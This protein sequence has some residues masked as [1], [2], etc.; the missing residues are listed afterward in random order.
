MIDPETIIYFNSFEFKSVFTTIKRILEIVGTN[1]GVFWIQAY[2]LTIINCSFIENKAFIGGVG[3][4]RKNSKDNL[5]AIFVKESFFS[6]NEAGPTSGVFNFGNYL[7][8]SASLVN[9]TFYSN[10]AKRKLFIE[11]KLKF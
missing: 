9:N 6:W 2:N 1:G 8:L 5:A 11:T 10:L 4:L 7:N 3:Y